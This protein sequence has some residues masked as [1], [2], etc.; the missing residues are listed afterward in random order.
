MRSRAERDKLSAAN[1]V[2]DYQSQT[3]RHRP[4]G[5][6]ENVSACRTGAS[7]EFA[8]RRFLG[9]KYTESDIDHSSPVVC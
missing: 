4:R 9:A 1:K 7:L 8:R 6:P 3:C 2:Q 5:D